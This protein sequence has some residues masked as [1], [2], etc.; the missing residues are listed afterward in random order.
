MLSPTK[1]E[2][3]ILYVVYDIKDFQYSVEHTEIKNGLQELVLRIDKDMPPKK[4][5]HW[6]YKESRKSNGW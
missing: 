1:W 4:S 3:Y 6:F 2:S 5:V